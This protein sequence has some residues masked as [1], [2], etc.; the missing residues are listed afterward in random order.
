[1]RENTTNIIFRCTPEFKKS[2]PSPQSEFIK[3]AVLEKLARGDD[4]ARQPAPKKGKVDIVPLVIQDLLKREQAGI[5]E[6]GTPLQAGNGR[7]ALVDAYQE[8]LDMAQYLKQAILERGM[9]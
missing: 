7:D 5:K 2:V 8:A 4:T 3:Q 1:M 6:Y 9:Q